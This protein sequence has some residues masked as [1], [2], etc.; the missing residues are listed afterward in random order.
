MTFEQLFIPTFIGALV[1]FIFSISLFYLTEKWKRSIANKDLNKNIQKESEYN[2]E[3]LSR[4]KTNIDDAI[5]DVAANNRYLRFIPY[6]Y[7]LQRQFILE[8]FNKGLLYS[9]LDTNEINGLDS[10]LTYFS[11]STDR[12]V[13][14]RLSAFKTNSIT[15]AE[16]LLTLR[17]DKNQVIKYQ[18]ILE[19]IKN[20][21]KDLK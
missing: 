8:A 6:F 14:D 11:H 13:M 19:N 17:Y 20:K 12:I 21:L 9:Y 10:M 18:S 1:A 2:L 7:K 16:M 3:Y 15:Q 4:Q 5:N